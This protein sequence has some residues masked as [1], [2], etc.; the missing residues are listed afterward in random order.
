MEDL[1]KL[2]RVYRANE[3][4]WNPNSLGFYN[5]N[6]RDSAWR[7]IAFIFRDSFTIDQLK[8][9]I[10]KL[11]RYYVDECLAI[12]SCQ[13]QGLS[14]VPRYSFFEDLSFLTATKSFQLAQIRAKLCNEQ[15]NC[16]IEN[17]DAFLLN[18]SQE[19]IP[20]VHVDFHTPAYRSCE[21]SLNEE[22]AEEKAFDSHFNEERLNTSY[23]RAESGTDRWYPTEHCVS[24]SKNKYDDEDVWKNSTN[25][26]IRNQPRAVRSRPYIQSES[27]ITNQCDCKCECSLDEMASEHELS[28]S[29]SRSWKKYEKGSNDSD[30][31]AW[32]SANN[33]QSIRHAASN[34]NSGTNTP[35]N[36]HGRGSGYNSPTEDTWSLHRSSLN[37]R[38]TSLYSNWPGPK[39]CGQTRPRKYLVRCKPC[40]KTRTSEKNCGRHWKRNNEAMCQR[41]NAELPRQNNEDTYQCA[42]KKQSNLDH[43]RRRSS[44]AER[45]GLDS[46]PY[47][48]PY[49]AQQQIVPLGNN[50]ENAKY[51]LYFKKK[52][53]KHDYQEQPAIGCIQPPLNTNCHCSDNYNNSTM[54]HCPFHQYN[55]EYQQSQQPQ[56][57]APP[58]N[59]MEY[60]P[61]TDFDNAPQNANSPPKRVSQPLEEPSTEAAENDLQDKRISDQPQELMENP[62]PN[63]PAVS[64]CRDSGQ[65]EYVANPA[66][67]REQKETNPEQEY[68]SS[69]ERRQNQDPHVFKN[70]EQQYRFSQDQ[71]QNQDHPEYAANP[72]FKREENYSEYEN[73]T[74]Y[75]RCPSYDRDR[76]REYRRSRRRHD[77]DMEY[78]DYR[79]RRPSNDHMDERERYSRYRARSEESGR[80]RDCSRRRDRDD[81]E[82]VDCPAY[83]RRSSRGRNY[84][85]DDDQPANRQRSS[86][87]RN[88]DDDDDQPD[89]PIRHSAE[90]KYYDDRPQK[91]SKEKRDEESCDEDC[92]GFSGHRQDKE[93]KNRP[94]SK[95]KPKM[96]DSKNCGKK[97]C[98]F[99]KKTRQQKI[100]S[101]KPMEESRARNRSPSRPQR[102]VKTTKGR[103]TSRS[104]DRDAASDM[105]GIETETERNYPMECE[106]ESDSDHHHRTEKNRRF[107]NSKTRESSNPPTEIDTEVEQ[108]IRYK[109]RKPC[110]CP[111]MCEVAV[112]TDIDMT[113]KG[114]NNTK[115]QNCLDCYCSKEIVENSNNV[116]LCE[117]DTDTKSADSRK[118]T[119][120][121]NGN[122][123]NPKRGSPK[124]NNKN[125]S[126][127]PA[128]RQATS[129]NTANK[130]RQRSG[131]DAFPTQPAAA[132]PQIVQPVILKSFLM[133]PT[134]AKATM[135][136]INNHISNYNKI[137][138][139]Q[140]C[141][142]NKPAVRC[143]RK[144]PISKPSRKIQ[145]SDNPTVVLTG[146]P[147][148]SI[149]FNATKRDVIILHPPV[150]DFRPSINSFVMDD[151]EVK[152][153]KVQNAQPEAKSQSRAPPSPPPTKPKRVIH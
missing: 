113:L 7:R 75:V 144:K 114:R 147:F 67:E 125:S 36:R 116:L 119:Q 123:N 35:L 47:A 78:D 49:Q 71:R 109:Q 55:F 151:V 37:L 92:P 80:R 149:D 93:T 12:D 105:D 90:Q 3:C 153:V 41:L 8:S 84:N 138:L 148:K 11:K 96:E 19:R 20:S 21:A 74:Q 141:L 4:L 95:A 50:F 44:G 128:K 34:R 142:A 139:D 152:H 140:Q 89:R 112:E 98:S 54:M 81:I 65:S 48:Y 130:N 32:P 26:G 104:R 58:T 23:I 77:N 91:E 106:C 9:Q 86:R 13:R 40:A 52:R 39:L 103:S 108:D 43:G 135:G 5:T 60:P 18:S 61:N 143:L 22:E 124:L 2:I 30:I 73:H 56:I 38:S 45:H 46:N 99:E 101:E 132:M 68:R 64:P 72:E 24:C 15:I 134:I 87:R 145:V 6:L 62:R 51:S 150:K 131:F 42:Y 29:G 137:L 111:E 25:R 82:Y 66:I 133:P 53:R 59:P 33:S 136:I 27:T 70:E 63:P 17:A 126:P 10:R 76:H 1:P 129:M 69:L 121:S 107:S 115:N 31:S 97:E 85:D 94:S 110:K 16:T 57:P 88:Y 83:R 146:N 120:K 28:R 122:G 127:S 102:T 100:T 117:C 14:H 118:G 79:W